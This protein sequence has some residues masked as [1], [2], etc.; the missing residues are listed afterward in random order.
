MSNRYIYREEE[1]RENKRMKILFD[2]FDEDG[3]G[4]LDAR[5][6]SELYKANGVD[7]S[8]D[9]IKMLFG[10]NVYLTLENFIKFSRSKDDLIRY[11]H[12][13]KEIHADL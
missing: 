8:I 13:F 11:F 2:K 5:E 1:I 4:A 10:N 6:L 9:M 12:A 3:S 7:V